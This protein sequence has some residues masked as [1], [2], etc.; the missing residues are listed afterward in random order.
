MITEDLSLK[1][2]RHFVTAV[3]L[4]GG[5]G[6]RMNLDVTKQKLLIA[7]ESVLH[8]SVRAFEECDSVDA[9][10]VVCKSGETEFAVSETSDFK[11]VISV[12][13]GGKTRA[14]SAKLGFACISTDSDFVAIHDAARC[15]ITPQ[16][17]DKVI[18][19]A[20]EYGAA[21]AV[22]KVTDSIKRAGEDG[23][24]SASVPREYLYAAETPQVFRMEDYELGLERSSPD[25]SVTD[26]NMIV[27]NIGK[28]VFCVECD[29]E[30]IKITRP[31]DVSYAEFLIKR[32]LPMFEYR[33]GH[34]YDVH[35]LT[36]GRKLILGGVEIP[37]SL[38]LDG[39]SD[40]DV[41]IHAIMDALLGAAALGDIGRHFPDSSED[42]RDISSLKLLS[43]VYDKLKS[44]GYEIM[45][46]DSTLILQ[47]PK[48]AP[49]ID[50]MKSI[51]SKTLN[52]EEG[53]VNIKATTEERLGFTGRGEGVS[54]H[55]VAM[56]IKK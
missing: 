4:A 48:I 42:Y 38:G 20:F 11:K 52:L 3:I 55:S 19:A 16:M 5:S 51:I 15:M 2:N 1:D 40:A 6:S 22:K 54:A 17:I 39:H 34:G 50:E 27:E 56:V 26:D 14:E 49:Y 18:N 24:I 35:R 25:I 21:T 9:I 33:V 23:Y 28:K 41:L 8:R 47:K 31:E 7:G 53:R 43:S 44:A 29:C 10:V 12:T 32:R 36:E 30:N 46:I 37:Y 13:V 45:N